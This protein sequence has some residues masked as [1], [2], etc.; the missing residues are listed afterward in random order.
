[1]KFSVTKH[2]IIPVIMF[3]SACFVISCSSEDMT[4]G[5]TTPVDASSESET[6]ILRE[7]DFGG[8]EYKILAAAE[9]WKGKY[10]V[11]EADGDIVRDAVY[12]ANGTTA[13][14]YNIEIKYDVVNGYM[15]GMSEVQTRLKNSVIAGDMVYDLFV[16]ASAYV[17]GY[18]LEGVFADLNS[19][20][21]VIDFT[22]PWWYANVNDNLTVNGRLYVCSGSYN[23]ETISRAWCV[24][25]N[26]QLFDALGLFAPYDTVIHGKWTYD[27]MMENA[28][29]ACSDIDGDGKYTEA[30]RYGIIG[31][32]TEPFVALPY[33]M[34]RFITEIGSDG[35]PRLTGA[36]RRTVDI[37]D[38]LQNLWDDK[39]LYFGTKEIAPA[40]KLIPM[41]SDGRGLF[42]IYT[43][44]LAEIPAARESTDFGILPLPKFNEEQ[45]HYYTSS[46]C[47]ISAIPLV[48]RDFEMS[49]LILESLNAEYYDKAV[50]EYYNVALTRKLTRDNDS[51]AMIDILVEGSVMEFGKLF[52]S[53]LDSNLYN[54]AATFSNRKVSYATWWAEKG[55][56]AEAKLDALIEQL[57]Q[58]EK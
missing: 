45:E 27:G 35:A 40:D 41:F 23:L 49:A 12:E 36:P 20:P 4:G 28:V 51:A 33:G 19:L 5:E 47:D 44:N 50:P 34:G 25:F 14:N 9:Q 10:A 30:D 55:P 24:F 38:R 15:A 3:A 6:P 29:T 58:L 1:M 54:I 16:A 42:M 11:E 2:L 39:T 57:T 22:A 43:L 46:F 48:V 7:A 8:T 52:Y 18:I 53:Q 26:K 32:Q 13:Y 56:A 21:A 17:G 31:T 37:M